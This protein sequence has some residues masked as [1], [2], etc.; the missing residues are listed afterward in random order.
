MTR[1]STDHRSS[2]TADRFDPPIFITVRDRL[3]PLLALISWLEV[4]GHQRIV[5]ID[6]DSTYPPLLDYLHK[7]RHEVIWF[8]NHGSQALWICGLAPADEWF[9]LTDPDIIP[10]DDCPL[11]AVHYLHQLLLQHESYSKAALGLYLDDVPESMP[12]LTWERTLVDPSMPDSPAVELANGV[13]GTLSDTTFAL[14][15][16]G[17]EFGYEAIRTGA[18]FQ[19]RHTSWY[20]TNDLSDEDRYYLGRA[21]AGELWSSWATAHQEAA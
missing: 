4:A 6:N 20:A 18:P 19:A 16:P 21:E 2:V 14:H 8:D 1:P 12:S 11:Y 15:R 10:T 5:L 9:V 17:A 7:T 13:W 3:T